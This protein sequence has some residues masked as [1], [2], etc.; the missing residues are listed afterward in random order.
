MSLKERLKSKLSTGRIKVVDLWGEKVGVR[1]LSVKGFKEVSFNDT[2]KAADF[3]SKQFIDPVDGSE[4]LD[5]DDIT[6]ENFKELVDVFH[7][8]NTSGGKDA[9]KNS[10]T[11]QAG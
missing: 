2:A 3:L 4:I 6:I 11:P 9:E 7:D 10:E 8:A 5:V 1:L